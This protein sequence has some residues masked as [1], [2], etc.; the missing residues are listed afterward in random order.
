MHTDIQNAA[1]ICQDRPTLGPDQGGF[2]GGGGG[3]GGRELLGLFRAGA[4][5]A[6]I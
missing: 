3:G 6:K 1:N 5:P 4:I 2:E